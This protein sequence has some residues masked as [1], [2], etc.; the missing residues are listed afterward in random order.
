M[1]QAHVFGLL[2]PVSR[3]PDTVA[4]YNVFLEGAVTNPLEAFEAYYMFCD[5]RD[6]SG[7]RYRCISEPGCDERFQD[8]VPLT[9]RK[10]FG[11]TL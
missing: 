3:S 4:C 2:I 9:S 6:G 1:K 11:L 7:M 5:D 10:R 8:E